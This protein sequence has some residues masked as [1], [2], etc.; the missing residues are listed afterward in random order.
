MTTAGLM[1]VTSNVPDSR[2]ARSGAIMAAFITIRDSLSCLF[3]AL[4]AMPP[5]INP[6]TAVV[7]K[8]KPG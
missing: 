8:R 7:L 2:L 5:I 3:H 6:L 1:A 4:R